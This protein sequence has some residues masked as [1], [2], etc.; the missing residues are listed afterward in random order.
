MLMCAAIGFFEATNSPSQSH[1]PTKNASGCSSGFNSGAGAVDEPVTGAGVVLGAPEFVGAAEKRAP[2]NAQLR[3]ADFLRH[4]GATS[5]KT[6]WPQATRPPRSRARREPSA[7]VSQRA[8][9]IFP[10]LRATQEISCTM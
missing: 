6:R 9:G 7:V 8:A 5:P 3:F 10:S 4:Q 2:S 1:W